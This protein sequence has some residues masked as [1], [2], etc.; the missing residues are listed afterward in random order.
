MVDQ[1]EPVAEV[2]VE[3]EFSRPVKVEKVKS[4]GIREKVSASPEELQNLA[5]RLQIK[6][7]KSLEFDSLLKPWKKGGVAV[8]G[9]LS[10]KI[11]EVCVVT[12]E[13]FVTDVSVDVERFFERDNARSASPTSADVAMQDLEAF[14][15]ETPDVIEAGIIDIGE[16]AVEELA[17]TLS[18]HPRKPGAVFQDHIET[19]PDNDEETAAENPFA[20]LKNLKKH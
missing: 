4:K 12:L 17:L 2:P 9:T 19:D 15:D 3:R 5:Q 16:I 7:V 14:D 20:V 13:P 8:S 11:E 1:Y 18:P 10:A 6:A